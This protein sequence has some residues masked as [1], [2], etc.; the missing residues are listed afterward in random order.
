MYVY[1]FI[2][3][4]IVPPVLVLILFFVLL[5]KKKNP[6]TFINT[7]THTCMWVCM[8]FIYETER[9]EP[10]LDHELV[11]LLHYQHTCE[12]AQCLSNQ[13]QAL[14]LAFSI[15]LMPSQIQEVITMLRK[16]IYFYFFITIQR[17]F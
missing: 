4:F 7:Y 14:S 12:R 9:E 2:G 15:A 17:L 8:Y 1:M 10:A 5:F 13:K 16:L 6:L 3:L 11:A